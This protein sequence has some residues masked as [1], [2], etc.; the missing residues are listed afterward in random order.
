VPGQSGILPI[1]NKG[2]YYSTNPI[3]SKWYPDK[4]TLNYYSGSTLMLSAVLAP[5]YLTMMQNIGGSG[6]TAWGTYGTTYLDFNHTDYAGT[7]QA[8]FG[9][10]NNTIP[11]AY[12]TN[13]TSS[14]VSKWNLNPGT[15]M[16]ERRVAGSG[17]MA[18]IRTETDLVPSTGTIEVNGQ[19]GTSNGSTQ[20][21]T[22][23]PIYLW[24]GSYNSGA[25]IADFPVMRAGG[26]NHLVEV[27]KRPVNFAAVGTTNTPVIVLD[28]AQEKIFINGQAVAVSNGTG[29]FSGLTVNGAASV[30]GSTTIT[31]AANVAGTS[32]FNNARTSPA[33]SNTLVVKTNTDYSINA[34]GVAVVPAAPGQELSNALRI[35]EEGTILI[36]PQGGIPM[37]AFVNGPRP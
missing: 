19:A 3:E 18:L 33:N 1:T 25:T 26:A 8:V 13:S 31:G 22:N 12:M 34:Q 2:Q 6:G 21:L 28:P 30:T 23:S 11:W 15:E 36:K 16:M 32:T 7:R 9:Q 24:S 4:F 27:F 5:P 35:T 10:S 37:G 17:Q 20:F 14:F 29:V